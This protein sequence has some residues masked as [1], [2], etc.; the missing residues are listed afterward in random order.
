[1]GRNYR[2]H[3]VWSRE[4]RRRSNKGREFLNVVVIEKAAKPTGFYHAAGLTSSLNGFPGAFGGSGTSTSR[5]AQAESVNKQ[6]GICRSPDEA[7]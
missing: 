4:P 3:Q 2:S 7:A 5:F 1:M 6:V